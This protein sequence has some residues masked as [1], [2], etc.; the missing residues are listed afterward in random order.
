[1]LE[2]SESGFGLQ[3]ATTFIDRIPASL[4]DKPT[5]SVVV[6]FYG[7]DVSALIKCV[8][9]LLN[10]DYFQD[11]ITI[12]VIDNNETVSLAPSM[13]GGRCKPFH[14]PLPGSYAA[15]NRGVCESFDD[16][17]AFTDSDCVP[18]RSW[19]SAG[20]RALEEATT[21]V[22]VGGPIVFGFGGNSAQTACELLDSIIHHRQSEYIF[23]HGFAATA[24]LFVPRVL[25]SSY[26]QFDARFFS[27]GD[28]E[29]GQR[30]AA[31]GIGIVMADDAVVVHP[32][33][34]RFIDLLQK[35]LRGVGGD[36]TSLSLI[37]SSPWTLFK[38]QVNQY[39]HRQRLI[40]N[41]ADALGIAPYQLIKLR[42][43]LTLIYV[44]RLLE[45]IRLVFGGKPYRA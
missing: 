23:E 13:F 3:L 24:N 39:F 42:A 12:I 33:R 36:K 15:R 11:R 35:G 9:S 38:I 45:A 28:K 26:G 43:L 14:E 30:L 5:V 41:R 27:G 22:I 21:A 31:G 25:F 29:F 18:Q 40:S 1:M 20:V 4:P 6:P 34:K 16:I 10:Q 32:A 19:I 44:A 7:A 8:E 2:N 17:I 37:K